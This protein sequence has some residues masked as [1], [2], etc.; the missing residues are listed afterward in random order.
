MPAVAGFSPQANGLPYANSWP[1]APVVSIPTPFG[2]IGIGDASGGLC[3]GMVFVVNDLFV[4]GRQPPTSAAPAPKTAA[5]DYVT[6]RL[7]DSFNVP[8]G[9]THYYTWMAL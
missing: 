1:K 9:V 6:K 3:G 4:A 5:F 8:F 2:P 7:V